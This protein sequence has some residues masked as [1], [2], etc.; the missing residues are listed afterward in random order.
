MES[1]TGETGKGGSSRTGWRG[2]G[3]LCGS[4]REGTVGGDAPGPTDT[5][6]PHHPTGLTLRASSGPRGPGIL[7]KRNPFALSKA[8]RVQGALC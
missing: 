4:R 5:M 8:R 6:S 7:E 2:R 3:G 1:F